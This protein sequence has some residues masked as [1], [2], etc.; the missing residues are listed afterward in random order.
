MAIWLRVMAWRMFDADVFVPVP[1]C[2]CRGFGVA[3]VFIASAWTA[4]RCDWL[5]LISR[6]WPL[7]GVA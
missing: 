3:G 7:I 1:T 5:I 4:E 6:A 2:G